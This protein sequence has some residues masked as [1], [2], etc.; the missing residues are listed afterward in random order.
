MSA[1]ASDKRPDTSRDD[2]ASGGGGPFASRGGQKLDAA[3]TAFNI[4]ATSFAVADFGCNVGGFV[5]CW[6]KRGAARVYAVDTAY[7]VLAWTLRRDPR[8]VVMERTNALHARAPQ[9][10]RFVSVDAGWTRQELILPAAARWLDPH[11]QAAII[12]LIKPHYESTMAK[13]QRGILTP[14]QSAEVCQAVLSRL[15]DSGFSCRGLI[16]SPIEGQKGNV[17]YL[18]CFVPPAVRSSVRH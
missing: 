12:S 15:T 17:E 4:D 9:P 1:A 14:D 10:V 7:G 18:A 2:R 8:V 5:D 6:L 11:S 13:K 3:L 16:Q